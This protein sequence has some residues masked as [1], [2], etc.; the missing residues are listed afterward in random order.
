MLLLKVVVSPAVCSLPDNGS[1]PAS[2]ESGRERGSVDFGAK[3][4]R[5]SSSRRRCHCTGGTG[6]RFCNSFAGWAPCSLTFRASASSSAIRTRCCLGRLEVRGRVS[7]RKHFG[8]GPCL[9]GRVSAA[10]LARMQYQERLEAKAQVGEKTPSAE[11]ARLA[12]EGRRCP[13]R[14]ARLC[15]ELTF[16]PL[17]PPNAERN[18]E[19]GLLE[20]DGSAGSEP[21]TSSQVPVSKGDVQCIL[22]I[23]LHGRHQLHTGTRRCQQLA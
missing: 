13:R 2:K 9:P 16:A 20:E 4:G 22:N 5:C 3:R 21:A 6:C 18:G 7:G 12:C 17:Q 15:L 8:L 1:A 23:V 19:F 11:R 14:S 10:K